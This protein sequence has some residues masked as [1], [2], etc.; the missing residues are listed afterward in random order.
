MEDL[1]SLIEKS[2]NISIICS[3]ER[4]ESIAC[5]LALFYTL[6]ELKRNVNLEIK[7]I[8]EAL[9]LLT[10]SL[11]HI[12]CPKDF[13]ISIPKSTANI[14]Q[15]SYEKTDKDLKIS[16]KIKE[17]NVKKQDI[18]FSFNQP[19]PDLLISLGLKNQQKTGY[20][21]ILNIDNQK[22]NVNFGRINIVDPEKTLSE[23][24]LNVINS[25]NVKDKKIFTS[26]MI[27]T[28]ISL[29]SSTL[30]NSNYLMEKGADGKE[31]LENFY[32]HNN[33]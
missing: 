11:E 2:Q 12:S 22:E 1:K 15:I 20:F 29:N 18:S 17:G 5:A 19:N 32:K 7:E 9:K 24:T 8:P 26:L 27:G 23:L 6:K 21:S 16:F 13:S 30:P 33:Q 14:S 28:I 10:P 3:Q 25:F 31:I 4:I